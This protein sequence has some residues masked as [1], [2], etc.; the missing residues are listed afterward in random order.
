MILITLQKAFDTTD[1]EIL[2]QKLRPISISK[3]TLQWFRSYLS[4]Q[5]FLFNNENKPSDF[6]KIYCGVGTTRVY[7]KS[8]FVFGPCERYATSSQ[9]NFTFI[10]RW[11]MHLAP[12]QRNRWNWKTPYK[13]F[14]NICDWFVDNKLSINFGK[15]KTKSILFTSKR[16]SKNIH[17]LN[18]RYNQMNI[19]HHSQVTYLGC[20]LDERMS[21][22]PMALK[23][24]KKINRKLKFIYRKNRYFTLQCSYSAT[25][26]L[27]LSS[28]VP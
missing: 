23:V 12:I 14:E 7:Q 13:D 22:E 5:I 17:Q 3:G 26:W 10:C 1:H 2:L 6:G 21:C 24:I 8:C 20:V 16:R 27:C 9:I 28:L 11:F 18:I 25:F 15:D 19:K 4:E